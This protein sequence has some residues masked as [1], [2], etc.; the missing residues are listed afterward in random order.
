MPGFEDAGPLFAGYGAKA[1]ELFAEHRLPAGGPAPALT[2]VFLPREFQLAADTFDDSYQFIG[3][4]LSR[5]R[6]TDWRPPADDAPVLL[7]SLGTAF[8]NR[9]EF[10]ATCLEAFRDTNRQVVMAIGEHVD[11]TEIGAAAANFEI[12]ARIPQQAVLQHATAF[13]THAGMGSVMEALYHQ[14]PLLAAP[15]VHEATINANR[16]TELG[17]GYRLDTN[18][19]TPDQLRDHIERLAADTTIRANLTIMRQAIRTAGG[20]EAGAT[21]VERLLT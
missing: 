10:F 4:A 3:P 14:V 2:L 13:L 15:Q 7:V 19:P 21:A 12:A 16:V 17:L 18:S 9:P 1:A 6:A 8:N 20:A 5:A 11:R